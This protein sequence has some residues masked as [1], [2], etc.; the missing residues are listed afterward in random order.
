MD[1]TTALDLLTRQA[2]RAFEHAEIRRERLTRMLTCQGSDLTMAVDSVLTA[3]AE[4]APWAR[5]LKRIDRHGVREGLAAER[6]KATN[7]ILGFGISLS[8]SMITNAARLA[9][10]DGLRRFL[11][12]TNGMDIDEAPAE[13]PA[14]A[15]AEEPAPAPAEEA[16]PAE[17]V[18]EVPKVTPAQKRTLVAIRD[19]GVTLRWTGHSLKSRTAV[20]VKC[21]DRPR[22]DMV[23]WVISQKWA[24]YTSNAPMSA[25][26]GVALTAVGEAILAG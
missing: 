19:G 5:L 7:D 23:E 24:R 12:A 17:E 15:P 25:G 10:Q 18:T 13:E 21:G 8:T 11:S 3:E 16:A 4:A 14:P 2:E 26:R 1:A 6:E 9:E 22:V 20:S